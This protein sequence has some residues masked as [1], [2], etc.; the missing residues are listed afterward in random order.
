M[1]VRSLANSGRLCTLRI[2]KDKQRTSWVPAV[3][4]PKLYRKLDALSLG[5]AFASRINGREPGERGRHGSLHSEGG[6][7]GGGGHFSRL[8]AAPV[9]QRSS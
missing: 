2:R 4:G 6:G 7:G 9:R 3:V 5:R 1:W 8:L